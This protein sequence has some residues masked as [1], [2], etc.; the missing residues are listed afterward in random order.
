[1]QDFSGEKNVDKNDYSS[2][3][4]SICRGLSLVVSSGCRNMVD[5]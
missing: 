4:A 5:C 1:M 2:C 3:G